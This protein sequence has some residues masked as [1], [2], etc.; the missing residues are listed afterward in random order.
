MGVVRVRVEWF[1]DADTTYV[2]LTPM[3]Q[4]CAGECDAIVRPE[5]DFDA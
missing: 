1:M 4:H 3:V 5:R 2:C